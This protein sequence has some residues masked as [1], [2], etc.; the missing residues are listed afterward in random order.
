MDLNFAEPNPTAWDDEL[1]LA[2]KATN[3][4]H[5]ARRNAGKP[6]NPDLPPTFKEMPSSG[7]EPPTFNNLVSPL[8][9]A[10]TTLISSM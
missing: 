9:I 4:A 3:N 10:H 1:K 8:P 7:D 6:R 5:K 2:Q